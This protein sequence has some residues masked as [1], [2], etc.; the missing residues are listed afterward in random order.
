VI[1]GV[2][3]DR[4]GTWAMVTLAA[5]P[6]GFERTAIASRAWVDRDGLGVQAWADDVGSHGGTNQAGG[7]APPDAAEPHAHGTE[8]PGSPPAALLRAD[9]GG[10]AVDLGPGA[11]LR[12]ELSDRRDWP[13]RAWGALGPA[14]AV[15]GLGQYWTPHLLS[16]RV[17]GIATAGGRELDLSGADV[18]AEKNWGAAF[19]EHWW[20]GQAPLGEGAGVAFAGGRLRRAGVAVAPSAVVAWTPGGLVALAPPLART[21]ASAGGGA[22]RLHARSPRWRVELEGEAAGPPLRLPVPLPRERR[23]EVRSSHHLL[24]RVA[25]TVRRGRRVWLREESDR[26]ALE[27][28]RSP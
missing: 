6:G 22:W 12:A 27:D 7:A 2:C 15:P 11:R 21:V 9:A 13:R 26:A 24:G 5:E 18:Y 1:A 4:I 25:V 28:G 19:A 23:L 14:Q 10:L 17:A 16:A 20:W 8:R 3:R